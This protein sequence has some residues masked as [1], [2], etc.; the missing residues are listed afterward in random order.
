[1]SAI[2]VVLLIGMAFIINDIA[3]TLKDILK[4]LR[5]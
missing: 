3:W 1:M 4:E 2:I 5:K